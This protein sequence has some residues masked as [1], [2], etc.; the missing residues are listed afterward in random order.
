MLKDKK[1]TAEKKIFGA[2]GEF[3]CNGDV[4]TTIVTQT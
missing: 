1:L 2:W 3:E 4:T